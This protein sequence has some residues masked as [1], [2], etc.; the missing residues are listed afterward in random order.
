MLDGILV[1]YSTATGINT[2]FQN[3]IC[4]RAVCST[5]IEPIVR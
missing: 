3:Y 2:V 5:I 4:H 1:K